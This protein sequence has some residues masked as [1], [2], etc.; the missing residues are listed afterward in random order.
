METTTAPPEM[1][2]RTFA[3]FEKAAAECADSRVKLG[4]HFP[5]ATDAGLALGKQVALYTES[6]SL[7]TLPQR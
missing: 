3:S 1:P 4:W 6:H 5:Y 2:T 7:R